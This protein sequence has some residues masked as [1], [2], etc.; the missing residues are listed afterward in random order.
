MK[1]KKLPPFG[2]PGTTSVRSIR[3]GTS[4]TIFAGLVGPDQKI[5]WTKPQDVAVNPDVKQFGR[6]EGFAA[7]HEGAGVFLFGDG[8]TR[9][10]KD[11][12]PAKLLTSLFTINGGEAIDNRN[13][14]DVAVPAV[15]DGSPKG[16]QLIRT[17][18]GVKLRLLN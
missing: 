13:I 18:E 14:P 6:A 7:P 3:D 9:V 5:P 11:A 4:L 10:I 15:P 1:E 12:I 16:L 8:S 2:G 17:K